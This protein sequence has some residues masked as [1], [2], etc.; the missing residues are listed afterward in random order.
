[1]NDTRIS[2][3]GYLETDTLANNFKPESAMP[4]MLSVTSLSGRSQFED[5]QFSPSIS[6]KTYSITDKTGKTRQQH[7]KH[8]DHSCKKYFDGMRS[9]QIFKKTFVFARKWV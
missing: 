5:V 3:R 9:W 1:M 7:V 6:K 8:K 4:Q 2:W